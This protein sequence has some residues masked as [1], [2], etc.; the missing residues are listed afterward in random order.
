[1]SRNVQNVV[2]FSVSSVWRIFG[3]HKTV[4]R[5]FLTILIVFLMILNIK[6]MEN[7]V[8]LFKIK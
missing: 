8:A 5:L 1:M 2:Q 6:L 4:K 7:K 3:R